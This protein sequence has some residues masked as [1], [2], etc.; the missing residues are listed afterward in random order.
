[1]RQDLASFI[2]KS[3]EI[4]NPSTEFL[5]N[6][7]IDLISQYLQAA[8]KSEIK[9]LII[10]MPPRALKSHCSTVAWPAWL[11]GNNPSCRILASSYSQILSNKHSLDSRNV[12]QSEFYKNLFP[13]TTLSKG[14]NEK[15]KFSTTQSGFRFA[16]SIGGT[17]TGEG[18]NFLIVDDPHNPLQANS[19]TE[20]KKAIEWLEQTFTTRLDD[21]K[22]GVIVIVMQ[23]LHVDDLT[24]YLLAK[25]SGWELLKLPAITEKKTYIISSNTDINFTR[26]KGLLHPAREGQEEI[27]RIKL[28]LGSH[29][30]SAQYQQQPLVREDGII[31][32][33]W[34]KRHNINPSNINLQKARVIQSWD[35]A[36]KISDNSDYSVCLTFIE[37]D[38][39][40]YLID[41]CKEKLIYP[42]L[43]RKIIALYNK[44]KP[45]TLL[46]EDKA[47]GQSLIQDLKRESKMPIIPI[48]PRQDKATR[49]A[50]ASS[51]IEAGNLYLPQHSEWL[52]EFEL[53]LLN[54]PTVAHDDCVDA[55]SQFLEW[56][57]T[58]NDL[59][60]RMRAV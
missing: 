10:N 22:R 17:A 26:D 13:D 48:T 25:N 37:Q 60:P 6:W 50:K 58:R 57:R 18:G 9:R 12:I 31:K 52:A 42:D 16:T 30:F 34:L 23:R 2:A 39:G 56:S 33:N 15:N 14:Q 36:I 11:L 44:Y 59:H 38:N 41:L 53:E 7:H 8:T 21:K 4:T 24:G 3:F 40:H 29:A 20:R 5:N 35:T 51:V 19:N 54:F 46:L 28:E 47:S 49:L 43:K 27:S 32:H 1:M 55:L 45:E